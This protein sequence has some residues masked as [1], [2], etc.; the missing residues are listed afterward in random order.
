MC[1]DLVCCGQGRRYVLCAQLTAPQ[2][3]NYSID[4]NAGIILSFVGLVCLVFCRHPFSP[5]CVGRSGHVSTQSSLLIY[6][7][8]FYATI[9]PQK[10]RWSQNCCGT[11]LYHAKIRAV[12]LE[13]RPFC[14]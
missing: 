11:D 3:M 6:C 4:S 1:V 14:W 8:C 10:E 2:D 7:M 12:R 9:I 5:E 13:A